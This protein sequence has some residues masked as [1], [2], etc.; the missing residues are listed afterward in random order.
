MLERQSV[1]VFWDTLKWTYITDKM[2]EQSTNL[3]KKLYCI[4][5]PGNVRNPARMVETLGGINS[6]SNVRVVVFKSFYFVLVLYNFSSC[7]NQAFSNTQKK[8]ELKFRPEDKFCKSITA[9]RSKKAAFLMKVTVKKIKSKDTGEHE[10]VVTKTSVVGRVCRVFTFK[11]RKS[12]YF[13]YIHIFPLIFQCTFASGLMDFQY[14]PMEKTSDGNFA[15]VYDSIVP[16]DIVPQTWLSEDAPLCM[17]P[18]F[19][20]RTDSM[21]VYHNKRSH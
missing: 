14:L 20:C 1:T 12:T 9:E 18:A 3:V 13:N 7:V 17:I 4:E 8:L 19:F 10:R 5:Y 15:S 21:Q 6:I 11:G 16:K 2:D